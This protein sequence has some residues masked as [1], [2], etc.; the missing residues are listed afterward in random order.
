[1]LTRSNFTK[2]HYRFTNDLLALESASPKLHQ[3]PY[4]ASI[5]S[6]LKLKAWEK[7][8]SSI[9]DKAFANFILRG[10][11]QG[12]R[13]GVHEGQTFK[14][15]RRNLKSAYD[16]PE[17]VT[18]YLQREETLGRLARLPPAPALTAPVVQIS[19]FGVIP[20]KY[21]PNKWRLIVD[22]SSP[23]GHSIN[24][25]IPRELCSVSYTSIDHA[26]SIA[27]GLGTGSLLAKLDLKEAYR[28]V[29]VHPSDQRLLAV[30]WKGATFIDKALPFGLR[31]APKLF[32]AL[33]DAMMWCLHE[34]GLQTALHYLDDFLLLGPPGCPQCEQSLALTLALCE[35][36]GFPVA[37][38][39][40][41]G[42][43]TT[44]TFLGIEIDTVQG[45]IR[46]PQEKLCRLKSTIAL[47]MAKADQL[48][49]RASGKKRE[50]LSLIGLLTHAASVVRPGRAFLRNLIDA[51]TSRPS[52]D[53][54]VHLN[55]AT[56]ADLAWWSTFLGF[57]NGKSFMPP[58]GRPLFIT[59]DASGSWGCGAA[60]ENMWFQLQWTE[61]WKSLPIAPKELVPIV[62]AVILWGPHLVG[63]H[64]CCLCD[65]AAVVAVVNK[66]AA[67][68]HALSH[69][70]RLL[71]FAVAVLDITL[72]ARHLPGAQN[73]SADALSR[74]NLQLFLSLNPQASPVPAVIPPQLRE[75][76]FNRELRWISP[77][78]TA[79]LSASWEAALRLPPAL[80]TAQ[81]NDAMQ[82]SA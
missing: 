33:T 31:S 65:N 76:V 8:L 23:E 28:A 6:P 32:S 2:G 20:K 9:P 44:L 53:H 57:W 61:S 24:D 77:N 3:L 79:L 38:E 69:L 34:R 7:A 26:V 70:L 75:L 13:I 52:L 45:Q 39:K 60:Y 67:R 41:E 48:T 68:D 21:R 59:S 64:I 56:R 46:L 29:P 25:A 43:A 36:L 47:W 49:P 78:W 1:M 5:S 54:W 30:S 50:L 71:A 51:A 10:I 12:F 37:S 35:E 58:S 16:H 81:P 55:S 17:V 74:N 4:E 63:R 40:T 42:P 15:L 14:P 11:S 82:R 62:I 22:L 72:T 66:G 73:A 80:P 27:W 18:N 19:P